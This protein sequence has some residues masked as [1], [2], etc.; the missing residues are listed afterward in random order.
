MRFNLVI[1]KI[2][3]QSS[4]GRLIAETSQ[5][6]RET[7]EASR[8][9]S[10]GSTFSYTIR[11]HIMHAKVLR[12]FPEKINILIIKYVIVIGAGGSYSMQEKVR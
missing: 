9:R 4:R 11:L 10:R 8:K 2:L 3:H 7:I 1:L 5:S 6:E 12:I